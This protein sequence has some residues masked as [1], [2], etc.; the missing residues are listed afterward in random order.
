MASLRSARPDLMVAGD[1]GRGCDVLHA[2][3]VF[4]GVERCIAD[5]NEIIRDL[6]RDNYGFGGDPDAARLC[7]IAGCSRSKQIVS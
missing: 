5:V 3:K 7:L 1:F 6:A 4:E 2:L